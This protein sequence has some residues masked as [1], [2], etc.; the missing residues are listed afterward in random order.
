M[1]GFSSTDNVDANAAADERTGQ[2]VAS[3]GAAGYTA[4]GECLVYVI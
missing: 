1:R 2:C 3:Y 4:V